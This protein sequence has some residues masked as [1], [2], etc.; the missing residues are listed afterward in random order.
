MVRQESKRHHRIFG[1]EDASAL[2]EGQPYIA[3]ISYSDWL[4]GHSTLMHCL[5]DLAEI[6][7][8]LRGHGRY[9]VDLRCHEVSAGADR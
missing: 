6:L 5:E 1:G 7:L 2:P 3:Y 8:I 4:D 9:T